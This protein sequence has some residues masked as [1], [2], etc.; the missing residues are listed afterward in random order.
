MS[1][2]QKAKTKGYSDGLLTA[3]IF[4]QFGTSKLGFTG[5]YIRDS[6][7]ALGS[8]VIAPGNEGLYS[9]WFMR[10]LRDGEDKVADKLR[11]S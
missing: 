9:D 7:S 10:G 4:A 3:K 11:N 8:D 2:T 1:P 5:Q 6:I